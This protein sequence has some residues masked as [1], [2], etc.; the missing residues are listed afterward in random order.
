MGAGELD[1][2]PMVGNLQQRI[3]HRLDINCPGV[4]FE[5][6][7]PLLGIG[8]VDE[9][10]GD[11]K[12]RQVIGD[13]GMGAAVQAFLGEQVIPR[14]QHRQQSGRDRG[15]AAGGHHRRL[16]ALQRGEQLAQRD[17]VGRVVQ[18]DIFQ[19]FVLGLPGVLEG[20]GLENRHGHG[21]RKPRMRVAGMNQLGFDLQEYS[22][23]GSTLVPEV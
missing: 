2:H 7:P 17:M 21:A 8:C 20:R 14:L 6:A 22:P 10:E 4:G 9:V 15:H 11:S 16:S 5:H 3:G 1:H 12:V 19:V 13:E 18:A 23:E